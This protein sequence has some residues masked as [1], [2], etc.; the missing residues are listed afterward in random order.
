MNKK[1][2]KRMLI[3]LAEVL[4]AAGSIM[5]MSYI[6]YAYTYLGHVD[7]VS[8]S[9]AMTVV[10]AIG[11]VAALFTG[12]IVQ[13]TKSKM[14]KYRLWLMIGSIMLAVGALLMVTAFSSNPSVNMVVI[15]VG[16]LMYGISLDLVCTAKYTLYEQ[17]AHGDTDL[18]NSYSASAYA[19]GNIGF[20]VYPLILMTL[21]TIIGG[22]NEN[23]GFFGTQSIFSVLLLLGMI[24][25]LTISRSDKNDAVEGEM[26][27]VS[28]GQMMKGLFANKP[29]LAVFIGEIFKYLGY[30]LYNFLLVYLCCNVYGNFNMYNVVLVVVSIAGILGSLMAPY[31][32]KAL[33]GRKR[34]AITVSF[35]VAALYMLLGLFGNNLIVF[36]GVIALATFVQNSHDSVESM[37]YM[38]AGEYWYHKTGKDS[39]AFIM[40]AANIGIKISYMLATPI[41]GV[42]LVSCNFLD[43]SAILEGADA[44][45]MTLF[46]G[47][48]PAAGFALLALTL[49][50][51]HKV[52]DKEL[53]KCIAENAEKDAA[54]YGME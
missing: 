53:E 5:G 47:M 39:R 18:I 38:D 45:R 16:Y 10:S 27:T 24:I 52:S 43:E 33:K 25:L 37:L 4:L 32:I 23:M 17:M 50:I 34:T 8:M 48:L 36:Y 1:S 9:T 11:F 46:T 3:L 13:R 29:A 22:A 41:L 49:L 12:A 30:S 19:G 6:D 7:A 54:L 2:N 15:S 14:G 35:V 21:V 42:V 40:G 28:V 31:V 44:A 26:P 51:F 20:T